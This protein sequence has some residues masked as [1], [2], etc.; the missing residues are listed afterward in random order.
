MKNVRGGAV[1]IS[2]KSIRVHA[3]GG[4]PKLTHDDIEVR[5]QNLLPLSNGQT[6]YSFVY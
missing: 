1:S 3:H 5:K 6:V 2:S 4:R